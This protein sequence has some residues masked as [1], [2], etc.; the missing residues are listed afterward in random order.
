VPAA[1]LRAV[2]KIGVFRERIVLPS[3]GILDRGA[4]PDARGTVKIEK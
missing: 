2:G 3:A 1:Q 4:P